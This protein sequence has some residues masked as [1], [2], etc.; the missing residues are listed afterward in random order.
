MIDYFVS[1]IH[2]IPVQ[3]ERASKEVREKYLDRYYEYRKFHNASDYNRTGSHSVHSSKI[4][5]H[6]VLN[7]ILSVNHKT[8][9]KYVK[10][11]FLTF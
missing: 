4:N 3:W 8:C 10:Y 1:G 2:K 11:P 9:K 5:I 7:F 6:N